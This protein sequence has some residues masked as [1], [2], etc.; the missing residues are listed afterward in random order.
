[1][2]EI[3]ATLI[4]QAFS[5]QEEKIE[6]LKQENEKLTKEVNA[7]KDKH[8]SFEELHQLF[9][10]EL[11]KIKGYIKTYIAEEGEEFDLMEEYKLGEK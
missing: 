3:I 9:D 2:D 8:K 5:A 10:E 11:N 4:K 6:S 1:M 7:L